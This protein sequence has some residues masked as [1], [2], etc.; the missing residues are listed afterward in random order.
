[1][2]R[3]NQRPPSAL[4]DDPFS[5]AFGPSAYESDYEKHSRLEREIEAKRISDRIDDELRRD[6]ERF[7]RAKQ[8]VK[9]CVQLYNARRRK[10]FLTGLTE[11]R[12]SSY[13]SVRLSRASPPSRSS[14]NFSILQPRSTQSALPGRSLFFTT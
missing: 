7:K 4:G 1:M 5:R 8:D 3:A 10:T 9:V 2:L 12:R 13:C 14:F 6:R 11:C